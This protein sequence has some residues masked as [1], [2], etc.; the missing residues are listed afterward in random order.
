[1]VE[2]NP[3]LVNVESLEGIRDHDYKDT[4]III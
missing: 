2:K 1:M 3:Q 4:N